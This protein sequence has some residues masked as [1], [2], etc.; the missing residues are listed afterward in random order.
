MLK[1]CFCCLTILRF[2]ASASGGNQDANISNVQAIQISFVAWKTLGAAVIVS[3]LHKAVTLPQDECKSE[4]ESDSDVSVVKNWAE[5]MKNCT[6]LKTSQGMK[7]VLMLMERNRASC[8]DMKPEDDEEDNTDVITIMETSIM[9]QSLRLFLLSK[10]DVMDTPIERNE[11]S[12]NL[13]R[14]QY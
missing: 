4:I 3:C 14:N 11:I 1:L 6:I 5:F 10:N 2:V 13:P 12:K 7:F 8:D 9:V